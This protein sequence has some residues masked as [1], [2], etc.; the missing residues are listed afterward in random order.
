MSNTAAGASVEVHPNSVRRWRHRWAC[1]DFFL[2]DEAGARFFPSRPGDVKA[3][4]CEAVSQTKLP[5]SCLSTS[6]LAE[7][8]AAALGR[9]ISPSTVWRILGTDAISHHGTDEFVQRPAVLDRSVC[10]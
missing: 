4:A 2:A 5:L 9:S 6:D 1:G 8:A 7:H 10:L 3:F